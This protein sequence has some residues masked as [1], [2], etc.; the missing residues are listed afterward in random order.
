MRHIRNA[1]QVCQRHYFAD[2]KQMLQRLSSSDDIAADGLQ[3][4]H[5][6]HYVPY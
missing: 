1:G 4:E 5:V 2:H 3:G 6:I